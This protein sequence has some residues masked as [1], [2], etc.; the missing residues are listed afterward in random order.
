MR[1]QS[2]SLTHHKR[3]ELSDG[4]DGLVDV[5][6]RVVAT[7]LEGGAEVEGGDGGAGA[8]DAVGAVY[9]GRA[10]AGKEA[11]N[12]SIEIKQWNICFPNFEIAE[13]TELIILEFSSYLT[14]FIS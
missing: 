14:Q 3:P 7:E 10:V 13:G 1:I 9:Q 8:P 6:V 2:S 11:K 4:H 5:Y 12:E